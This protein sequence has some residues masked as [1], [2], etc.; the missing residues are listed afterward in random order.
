MVFQYGGMREKICPPQLSTIPGN[1][2]SGGT[3]YFFLQGRN[4]VGYNLPSDSASISYTAGQG[5]EITFPGDC[6]RSGENILQYSLTVNTTDDPVTAKVL[7]N[8]N[9]E[10]ITLPHVLT[11]TEDTHILVEASVTAFPTGSDRIPGMMRL[12]TS[13]GLVYRYVPSST[14]PDN[15]TTVLSTDV[16]NWVQAFDGFSSYVADTSEDTN[17][18]NLNV[19]DILNAD[20]IISKSYSLDGSAGP[21]RTYWITNDTTET[22]SQ[23]TRVGLSISVNGEPASE[24]F[25]SLIKIIFDGYVDPTDGLIDIV[26]TDGTTP[27]DDVGIIKDYQFGR[28]DL[29]LQ[30]PLLPGVAYQIRVFPQF[31][32]YELQSIPLS[33]TNISVLG[34]F[35]DEAGSFNDASALIGNIILPENAGLRRVYP[36]DGLSVFADEGSGTVGGFFFKDI[37]S[38]VVSGLVNSTADQQIVINNNGSVYLNNLP[39][40]SNEDLRALITTVPGESI[41]SDFTTLGTTADAA[42]DITV[43]VNYPDTIDILYDDVIAGTQNKGTFNAEEIAL[44][45]SNGTEIRKFVG[46]APT[47][48]ISD[49]FTVSWINGTV[50]GSVNTNSFGLWAPITPTAITTT[51][52][53]SV[54][55]EAAVSFVYLGNS[56]TGVSHKESDGVI[57]ELS[58]S[59]SEIASFAQYW[60]QPI[61]SYSDLRA[62]DSTSLLDGQSHRIEKD[63]NKFEIWTWDSSSTD[64]DNGNDVLLP[65]DNPTTG[66]W[67]KMSGGGGSLDSVV[68]YRGEVVV[69]PDGYI[70]T[71]PLGGPIIPGSTLDDYLEDNI[72][73]LTNV[74]ATANIALNE[75]SNKY[76]FID[77]STNDYSLLLYDGGPI[78]AREHFILNTGSTNNITVEYPSGTSLTTLT[79]NQ[80]GQVIWD[81]TQWRLI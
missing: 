40:E 59:I 29:I 72:I 31:N 45:I 38:N 10:D 64:T 8:L 6:L 68:T 47:N 52:T 55:Y 34:F 21:E 4:D 76:Q 63:D 81:K 66:R 20:A 32:S 26:L 51:T 46:L 80:Q 62:V 25:E 42:P 58:L 22:I 53:G 54:T 19:L 71:S 18:A 16:G 14:L 70:V 33:G 61:S 24:E 23:G 13:T 1:F 78:Y 77:G 75:Q 57:G 67:I 15:G 48:T 5:I 69:G 44:F 49:D 11:L 65:N 2:S 60:R 43:T 28:T 9:R 56:V 74:S 17:G 79:P 12:L 35:F 3:L 50:V 7:V 39:L 41:T 27:M 73:G 37:G 36:S 30:K